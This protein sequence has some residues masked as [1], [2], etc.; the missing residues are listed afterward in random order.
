MSLDVDLIVNKPCSVFNYN[1]THNLGAMARAVV[2]DKDLEE[3]LTL[4]HVLW[5]PEDFDLLLA[6]E[7][8]DHLNV[9]YKMLMA[10]PE[11]YKAF[12][13]QNGWGSYEGLVAFVLS[14]RDAC[15]ENP[16]A[17]VRASR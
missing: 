11:K 12:N 4:Y 9:G 17:E 6:H 14:Y 15:W 7:I 8:A 3:P 16:F 13:P 10:E 1:I 5:R 2:L